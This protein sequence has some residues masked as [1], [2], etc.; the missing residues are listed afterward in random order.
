MRSRRCDTLT[1][2]L[3]KNVINNFQSCLDFSEYVRYINVYICPIIQAMPTMP[4][5]SITCL[6]TLGYTLY[7]KLRSKQSNLGFKIHPDPP[8]TF[9]TIHPSSSL[10][11]FPPSGE[12]TGKS[13]TFNWEKIKRW[14]DR[15]RWIDLHLKYQI[16]TERM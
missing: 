9:L 3:S 4:I 2:R 15:Y 11:K 14:I 16:W 7:R 6:L 5:S 13:L 10:T 12:K 1:S 8:P